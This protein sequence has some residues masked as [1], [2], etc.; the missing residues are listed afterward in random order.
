MSNDGG[1]AWT[2]SV[3]QYNQ[4]DFYPFIN[5]IPAPWLADCANCEHFNPGGDCAPSLDPDD[6]RCY[7]FC[8]PICGALSLT[9]R[10][11]EMVSSH[12]DFAD[13]MLKARTE[14]E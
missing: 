9:D 1:P 5:G 4:N 13:A 8:G 10:A 7:A 11:K 12:M 6:D 14:D 2:L 3:D